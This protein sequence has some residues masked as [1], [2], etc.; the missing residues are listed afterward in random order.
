MLEEMGNNRQ[1][2]SMLN[3]TAIPSQTFRLS[4]RK[5]YGKV[6]AYA[7]TTRQRT[8]K[9]AIDFSAVGQLEYPFI[10]PSLEC[11]LP[12]ISY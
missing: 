1:T 10:S 7:K 11:F 2:R 3:K 6:D 4:P 8:R 9:A 12:S 5:L